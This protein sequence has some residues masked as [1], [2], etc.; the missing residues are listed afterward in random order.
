[1]FELYWS[2][3]KTAFETDEKL[4]NETLFT[5]AFYHIFLP[6]F[7]TCFRWMIAKT[8]PLRKTNEEL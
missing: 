5:A 1:M 8:P 4:S 7:L 2:V 3:D 6:N